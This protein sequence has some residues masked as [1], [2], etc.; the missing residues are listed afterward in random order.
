MNHKA[1]SEALVHSKRCFST[2]KLYENST[3]QI[4]ATFIAIEQVKLFMIQLIQQFFGGSVSSFFHHSFVSSNLGNFLHFNIGLYCSFK[5]AESLNRELAKNVTKPHLKPY[6]QIDFLDGI[7]F[8]LKPM[9]LCTLNRYRLLGY[10]KFS[11]LAV[12]RVPDSKA[13]SQNELYRRSCPHKYFS[14]LNLLSYT[15]K[16]TYQ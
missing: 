9:A 8:T 16:M 5:L 4:L 3:L 12:N 6:Q 10:P 2:Q 11:I 7:D 13:V 1:A 15:P 14:L